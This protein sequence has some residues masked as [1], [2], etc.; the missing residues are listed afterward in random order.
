[1][2]KMRLL[3]WT[4]FWGEDFKRL[5]ETFLV[6]SLTHE[7]NIPALM[8]EGHEVGWIIRTD[9][10]EDVKISIPYLWQIR[11]SSE[12]RLSDSFRD[13]IRECIEKD[14]YGLVAMPDFFFGKAS[15]YNAFKAI[16]GKNVI[17][18]IPHPRVKLEDFPMDQASRIWEN[19]ELVDYAWKHPHVCFTGTRDTEDPNRTF[20][21]ISCRQIDEDTLL[22]VHNQA[23]PI[24]GKYTAG[25]LE[26]FSNHPFGDIDHFWLKKIADEKRV[27]V[28]GSSDFCFF[29]EVCSPRPFLEPRPGLKYNDLSQEGFDFLTQTVS[30]WKR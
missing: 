5:F 19:R 2:E 22:V 17:F 30:V 7:S 16:A 29:V 8:A 28:C 1:M 21:G 12:Q 9:Q 27:R 23:A 20:D 3:I 6:P 11:P 10:P 26:Y 13:F 25:D 4:H 24:I 18:S 14:A 15:V